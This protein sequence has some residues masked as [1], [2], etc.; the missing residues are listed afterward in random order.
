[1]ILEIDKIGNNNRFIIYPKI[2]SRENTV[3]DDITLNYKDNELDTFKVEIPISA[4]LKPIIKTYNQYG[5]FPAACS[6]RLSEVL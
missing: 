6:V 3:Y 1:M 2:D 4:S 5:H